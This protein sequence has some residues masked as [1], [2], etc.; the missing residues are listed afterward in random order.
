MLK[1]ALIGCGYIANYQMEAWNKIPEVEIVAVCDLV[2]EK[3]EK[4]AAEFGVGKTYTDYLKMLDQTSP[5]F[6]DIAT[7]PAV[8]FEII[9]AAVQRG[10]A[11]LCQKPLASTLDEA[12]EMV[13]TCEKHSVPFMVN[14]NWRFRPWFREMRRLI[15]EGE[16]GAPYFAR[17]IRRNLR[18]LPEPR[19]GNQPYF[20]EM[21]K[22]I[23]YESGIHYID[24]MRYLLGEIESV[25][26]AT[27]KIGPKQAGE[28]FAVLILNFMPNQSG[29]RPLGLVDSNWCSQPEYEYSL[30]D[31]FRLEG[32]EGTVVTKGDGV[33]HLLRN[34]GEKVSRKTVDGPAG[35][36]ESFRATQAHFA[37][38]LL[39]Q[40]EFE[41]GGRDN[42][43]TLAAVFAAYESAKKKQLITL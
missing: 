2:E 12:R 14:E 43:K 41:T 9:R 19:F 25:Y 37:H 5:D 22:F 15:D 42:L 35:Y 40:S 21:P 24:T 32:R 3:A 30:A 28:D 1:G 6:V 23:I 17:F 4:M 31:D 34:D 29:Q 13:K 10:I 8:H 39:G 33:V 26:C 11:V 18:T 7:R 27:K 38:S 20:I 16:V 36:K